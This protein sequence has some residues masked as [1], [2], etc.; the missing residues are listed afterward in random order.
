MEEE[1]AKILEKAQKLKGKPTETTPYLYVGSYNDAY[2]T[3][4]L[5][6][7]GITHVLNCA[8][9]LPTNPY[10]GHE[11]LTGVRFYCQFEAR[12]DDTYNP[13]RHSNQTAKFIEHA[14]SVKGKV[15]LHCI[16]GVNRSVCLTL[17][18]LME[19]EGWDLLDGIKFMAENRGKCLENNN[20][21]QCL[22][23]LNSKLKI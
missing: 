18:Y 21:R 8:Q 14:R 19:H 13:L 15:L 22:I 6:K 7:L 17:A 1:I 11:E 5:K 20:F 16:R 4:L 9:V 10:K 12:D 23:D 3:T 2:D